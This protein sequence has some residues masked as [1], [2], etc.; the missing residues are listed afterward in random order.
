[1]ARRVIR[2]GGLRVRATFQRPVNGRSPIGEPYQGWEDA[3]SL[4]VGKND[5]LG[6]EAVMGGTLEASNYVE[7]WARRS[8]QSMQIKPGWRVVLDGDACNIRSVVDPDGKRADL[9][10]LAERGV[11]T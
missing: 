2:S 11:A 3:F 6:R 1:M 8:E 4:W 9:S 7:L 5:R 10:I